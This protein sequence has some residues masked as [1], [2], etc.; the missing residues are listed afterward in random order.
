MSSEYAPMRGGI[1]RDLPL[2]ALGASVMAWMALVV[3]A[4]TEVGSRLSNSSMAAGS[5]VGSMLEFLGAWEV[6][7]IAMMLPSSLGFLV[8]FRAATSGS[9]LPIVRRTAVCVGYALAWAGVG[10]VAMIA[11]GTLYRIEGLGA[12]LGGH[13]NLLAGSVLLL[14]GVFQFTALKQRC[15]AICTHPGSFFMRH[16]RRGAGNALALGARYGLA[17]VGCCW[18]LMGMMVVAGGGN[19]YLMVVLS[20][21]MF[22]ERAL[23]WEKRFVAAVGL[24]CIALGVLLAVSPSVMPLFTHNAERWVDMGSMQLPHGLWCRA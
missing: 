16:Y 20:A 9:R 18:A 1:G 19:L 5:T 22:A 3:A 4:T 12:W 21:I 15:L 11:S 24:T 13:P 23:G 8:L 7:V 14:A 2:V 17:C 6:M 10:W